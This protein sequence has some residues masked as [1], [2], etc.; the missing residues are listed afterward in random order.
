MKIWR[1][2]V[3]FW[4][5]L[6][7]SGSTLMVVAFLYRDNPVRLVIFIVIGSILWMLAL[8]ISNLS[9][10]EDSFKSFRNWRLLVWMGRPKA[11]AKQVEVLREAMRRNDERRV[12]SMMRSLNVVVSRGEKGLR[13]S[14]WRVRKE[15][16]EIL[17]LVGELKTE[18]INLL[19]E[20]LKDPIADVRS[21]ARLALA[22]IGPQVLRVLREVL[23]DGAPEL[24]KEI[25]V[26]IRLMKIMTQNRLRSK[27]WQERLRA[28]KALGQM[29]G[30]AQKGDIT[31]LGFAL[32]D[33][34]KEVRLA[35]L[36]ALISIGSSDAIPFLKEALE[37]QDEG[38]RGE[39]RKGLDKMRQRLLTELKNKD[40]NIRAAAVKGLGLIRNGEDM[41]QLMPRLLDEFT[42]ARAEA[43]KAIGLIGGK[44]VIDVL[45]KALNDNERSIRRQAAE[46]LGMMGI[47][48]AAEPLR[49]AEKKEVNQE[50][51]QAIISAL[52]KI[53]DTSPPPVAQED[54]ELPLSDRFK[55]HFQ[56][57]DSIKNEYQEITFVDI[58]VA[59]SAT[60][61]EGL[62]KEAVVYSFGQYNQILDNLTQKHHGEE[63]NRIG[64]E[65]IIMFKNPD[66]AVKMGIELHNALF[67]F[68][69]DKT[70]N[71][72][73][74]PFK[75]RT[76]INTGDCLIDPMIESSDVADYTLDVACH[77]QKYGEPDTIYMSEHTYSS[78]ELKNKN[79]FEGPIKFQRD[80]IQIYICRL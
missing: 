69:K 21:A 1:I 18:V 60:I 20:M 45:I 78:L 62:S 64:D 79:Q 36:E 39:A 13:H 19:V 68:N 16:V 77:L 29:V 5:S 67:E 48:Q 42:P 11:I 52:A 72:L 40:G 10:I 15:A 2:D 56:L 46:T 6:L 33:E 26:C 59:G 14:N 61:K 51:H 30:H 76:G 58:D 75:V 31:Y 4:V 37:D 7:V 54:T 66:N 25:D 53:E 32:N 17:G 3:V 73:N 8:L 24:S 35:V 70:A 57:Q 38:I 63:F 12:N 74:E 28:V 55:K 80:N 65:R 44:K 27:N 47:A 22:N 50:V 71:R 23:H 41:E 43:V 49:K 9:L 34:H